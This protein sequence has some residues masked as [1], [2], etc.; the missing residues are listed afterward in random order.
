M[1]V[2]PRRYG[3]Y[4]EL[5]PYISYVVSLLHFNEGNGATSFTDEV[6]GSWNTTGVTTAISSTQLKFGDSS[7]YNDGN[8][9]GAYGFK[10][11]SDWNNEKL[12]TAEA[13]IYRE[14]INSLQQWFFCLSP[15]N[16]NNQ[17]VR[18]Y[19]NDTTKYLNLWVEGVGTDSSTTAPPLNTWAHLAMCSD[20]SNY[21]L[22]LDG[23]LICQ[24]V[25]VTSNTGTN[26][27]Y[28]QPGSATDGGWKF[29]G[30]M[31]EV[32]LTKGVCRYPSGTTFTPP[33]SEFPNP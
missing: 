11:F 15:R 13:W 31:D 25:G 16:G 20:G 30:Y 10:T 1:Y 9:T 32:R 29:T 23:V 8:T 3:G 27:I 28:W 2:L 33:S 12:F 5:D 24:V 14:S 4:V 19:L 21:Y 7:A 18:V 26:P 22:Y 6:A 17:A